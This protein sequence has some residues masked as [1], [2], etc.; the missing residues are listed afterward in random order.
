MRFS[1]TLKNRIANLEKKSSSCDAVLVFGDGSTRAVRIRDPLGILVAGMHRAAWH[2]PPVPP[3]D[4]PAPGLSPPDSDR[5]PRPVSPHDEILDL[6]ANA[7]EI[8][9]NDPFLI[10]ILETAQQGE[11]KEAFAEQRSRSPSQ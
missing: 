10:L 6:M 7:R 5:G 9:P 4:A 2:G 8:Q 1:G 11:R 3:S